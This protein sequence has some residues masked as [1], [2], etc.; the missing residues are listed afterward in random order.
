MARAYQLGAEGKPMEERC[1]EFVF[2]CSDLLAKRGLADSDLS[3][4]PG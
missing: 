4:L 3:L 2:Q 1:P